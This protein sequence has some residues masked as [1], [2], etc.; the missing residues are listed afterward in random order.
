MG[1]QL[2]KL[3]ASLTLAGATVVVSPL[4]AVNCG[5]TLEGNVDIT[6][7]L[8]C[9]ESPA[10]RIQGPANVS[11]TGFRLIGVNGADIGIQ[12]IGH[13]AI[14]RNAIVRDFDT[15]VAFAIF[16][17]SPA[18]HE[19]RNVTA[20]ANRRAG[21]L[22]YSGSNGNLITN[23]DA[24]GNTGIGVVVSGDN[25]RIISNN[26]QNNNSDGIRLSSGAQNNSV[27]A[28]TSLNND[29]D[30]LSGS[31]DMRDNNDGCDN[32]TWADNSFNTRN[33]ACIN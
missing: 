24:L 21:F 5:D 33:K 20:R 1:I 29:A 25:N 3:I 17:G 2:G 30:G 28:N 9:S 32:N 19:V 6:G 26:V 22:I 11:A 31:L 4:H 8:H 10:L 18:S 23:S 14:L 13:D 27:R 15:G 7:D 12:L 16:F